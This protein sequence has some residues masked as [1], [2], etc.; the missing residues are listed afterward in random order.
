MKKLIIAAAIVC[1]AAMSHA[2]AVTWSVGIAEFDSNWNPATGSVVLGTGAQTWDFAFNE[3]GSADGSIIGDTTGIFASG[4]E[5][6]AKMTVELFNSDASSAGQFEKT[7]AFTM[8]TLTG[9]PT[10]DE[11][12][13]GGLNG[14][15][16]AG[17][18]DAGLGTLPYA[19]DAAA[20]G[21]SAVPEPTSGLLLLLGMAGLA[22]KRKQA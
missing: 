20:Q 16:A 5:W 7:I 11:A 18:A 17:F 9:D 12:I 14:N 15:I 19:S 13:L 22:L 21:W 2:A 3:G 10:Q 4:T 6:T 1:A 8:P